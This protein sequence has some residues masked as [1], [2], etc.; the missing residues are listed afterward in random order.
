MG[1]GATAGEG[2]SPAKFTFDINA[3]ASC[4]ND[5]AVFKSG[6]T[7]KASV[8]IV[9]FNNLYAGA[10]GLCSTG[11]SVL[12]AYHTKT[13]SGL[14]GTFTSPTLSFDGTQV[15]Y[16]ESVAGGPGVLHILRWKS[17]DGGTVGGPVLVTTSGTTGANYV[18][19]KGTAKSSLL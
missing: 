9:G 3:T 11:P 18:T 17:G 14:S 10:G 19:C 6:V 16:T 4:A 7:G 1:I 12:F 15:A 5:F 2:M 8:N 13:D